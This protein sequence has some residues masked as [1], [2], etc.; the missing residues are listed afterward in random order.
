MM[1][2][3]DSTADFVEKLLQRPLKRR[4]GGR[5]YFATEEFIRSGASPTDDRREHLSVRIEKG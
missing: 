3:L 1:R 5:E 2:V 4:R